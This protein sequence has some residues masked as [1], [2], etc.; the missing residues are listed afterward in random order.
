MSKRCLTKCQ[1]SGLGENF[2]YRKRLQYRTARTLDQLLCNARGEH[3]SMLE[4]VIGAVSRLLTIKAV[5]STIKA[6]GIDGVVTIKVVGIGADL[7]RAREGN[8]RMVRNRV[9]RINVAVA[10]GVGT[11]IWV[12]VLRMLLPENVGLGWFLLL[13]LW[14]GAGAGHLVNNISDFRDRM[15]PQKLLLAAIVSPA[16]PW[17]K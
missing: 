9:Q 10:V 1:T 15:S 14:I 8:A 17:L 11:F 2:T 5:E 6:V 7:V 3:C 16:W 4:V 12:L 13:A